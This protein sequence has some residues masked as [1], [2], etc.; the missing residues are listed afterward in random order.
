MHPHEVGFWLCLE[1]VAE[2][3][4]AAAAAA[5]NICAQIVADESNRDSALT[6]RV[7]SRYRKHGP[8]FGRVV[9]VSRIID[10]VHFMNSRES[11][12]L[13]LCDLWMYALRRYHVA[14]DPMGGIVNKV[15][16]ALSRGRWFPYG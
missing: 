16:S 7:L 4:N 8:P 11:P 5:P 9:D 14:N 13:Q 1:G 10:I 15:R 12:H 2:H 6:R 3:V